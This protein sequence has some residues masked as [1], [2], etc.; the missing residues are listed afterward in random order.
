[1]K[2]FGRA[3]LDAFIA[4]AI[5]DGIWLALIASDFYAQHLGYIM[6]QQVIW[7]AAI[8]FYFL[9]IAGVVYLASVPAA[10]RNNWKK[11]GINGA[12]LG[13]VAYG[14]YDLTNYATLQ[15]WPFIVLAVD[16]LWGAFVSSVV[17]L[18]GFMGARRYID[19]QRMKKAAA[20]AP[21]KDY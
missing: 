10:L 21:Y 17:A 20:A 14:T 9:Y 5:L 19:A 18:G 3:Y 15:G 16:L 11:A 8:V 13:L 2:L 4:F 7:P 12:V 1:M 6:R